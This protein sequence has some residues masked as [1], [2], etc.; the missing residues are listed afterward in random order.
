MKIRKMEELTLVHAR[1]VLEEV[2]ERWGELKHFQQATLDFL[3]RFS[4]L[5]EDAASEL[6]RRLCEEHGLSRPTAVQIVN[7]MPSSIEELR[8]ILIGEDRVF[9]TE[10]LKKIMS[11]LEEF[12]K[13]MER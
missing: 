3:T 11:L 8:Q 6:L 2:K 5:S 9:L 1:R 10:D 7:I 13:P 12:R 4:K